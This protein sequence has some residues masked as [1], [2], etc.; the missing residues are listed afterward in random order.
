MNP[1]WGEGT[2]Y[3]EKPISKSFA[4]CLLKYAGIKSSCLK[5]FKDFGIK[6]KKDKL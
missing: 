6:I 4:E 5:I 1:K 3:I 2:V